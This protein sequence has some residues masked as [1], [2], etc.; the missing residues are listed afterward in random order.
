MRR[1]RR[2][3]LCGQPLHED[4]LK[5]ACDWEI[6]YCS[7]LCYLTDALL[8]PVPVET[9]EKIYNVSGRVMAARYNIVVVGE[10][11]PIYKECFNEEE[12]DISR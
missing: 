3:R 4:S 9:L 6:K 12:D 11:D 10:K 8:P 7:Y 2:C 5:E 1:E